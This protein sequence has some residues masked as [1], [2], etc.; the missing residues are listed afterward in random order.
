MTD[1]FTDISVAARA[2]ELPHLLEIVSGQ[3]A[4][5][6]I[7]EENI[8]R[9][10]LIVEELFVN[11]IEHGYRGDSEQPVW[12]SLTPQQ[13]SLQLRY[14]D[15]AP[16]FDPTNFGPKFASTAEIGGLGLNLVRSMSKTFRY[17]R[18]GDRNVIDIEL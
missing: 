17:V 15:R 5:S 6:S 7:S 11:S 12:L 10:Q 14:Q 16:A 18:R 8:L 9:L 1:H 4:S 3:A 13:G 2:S